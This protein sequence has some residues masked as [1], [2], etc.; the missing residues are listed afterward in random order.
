MPYNIM[1]SFIVCKSSQIIRKTIDTLFYGIYMYMY[2]STA[3]T[4]EQIERD[5]E[6]NE[7]EEVCRDNPDP[8]PEDPVDFHCVSECPDRGNHSAPSEK[9]GK[10][11]CFGKSKLLCPTPPPPP[12][13]HTSISVIP[14]S[15]SLLSLPL[16]ACGLE[17]CVECEETEEPGGHDECITCMTD[18]VLF[19]GE[20]YACPTATIARTAIL[21][22]AEEQAEERQNQLRQ[23]E[24]KELYILLGINTMLLY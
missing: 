5:R 3:P 23:I 21:Q 7:E 1:C 20:C 18:T 9:E 8:N 24:R 19:E 10:R 13:T 6:N 14:L 15:L 16:S 12:H 2:I 4:A 11:T 17:Y 22:E